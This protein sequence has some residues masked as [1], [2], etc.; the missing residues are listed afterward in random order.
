MMNDDQWDIFGRPAK[1]VPK[2]MNIAHLSRDGWV[3][4]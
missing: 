2:T 1:P 4:A 3:A